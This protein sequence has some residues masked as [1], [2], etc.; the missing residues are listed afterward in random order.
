MMTTR[1]TSNTLATLTLS[2]LS[3]LFL[4]SLAPQAL[5]GTERTPLRAATL[6]AESAQSAETARVIVRLRT[7]SPP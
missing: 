1:P 4:T 2:A 6:P 7:S 5:A 3:A